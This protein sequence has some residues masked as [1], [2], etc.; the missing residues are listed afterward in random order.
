VAAAER[1]VNLEDV[2]K[3]QMR[4]VHDLGAIAPIVLTRTDPSHKLQPDRPRLSS[5]GRQIIVENSDHGVQW[6]A[7]DVVIRAIR[8]VV[9][10]SR[11]SPE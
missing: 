6:G 1:G 2:D 9:T 3:A 4:A 5:G 7:P 10:E 8:D 11:S